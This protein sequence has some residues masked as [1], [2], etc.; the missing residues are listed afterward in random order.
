MTDAIETT[1]RYMKDHLLL[2]SHVVK[3]CWPFDRDVTYIPTTL[4]IRDYRRNGIDIKE[5]DDD[6]QGGAIVKLAE[7]GG[8]RRGRKM[9]KH[10]L[11]KQ[12]EKLQ[13][14]VDL[15]KQHGH[16]RRDFLQFFP[17][18][19]EIIAEFHKLGVEC[20][21]SETSIFGVMEKYVTLI[22]K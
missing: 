8:G 3:K 20:S 15:T 2:T 9:R 4:E 6:G 5:V 7:H 19:S 22:I 10:I 12:R 18:D 14:I 11:R 13:F 21:I 1:L 17:L 16:A